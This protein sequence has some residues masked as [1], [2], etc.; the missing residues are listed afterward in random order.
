MLFLRDYGPTARL[1]RYESKV[2]DR[3][4]PGWNTDPATVYFRGRPPS[5]IEHNTGGYHFYMLDPHLFLRMLAL[6]WPSRRAMAGV[7]ELSG[8]VIAAAL[9][10]DA[11]KVL[12]PAAIAFAGCEWDAKRTTLT[13][14]GEASEPT[15]A[16]W[17]VLWKTGPKRVIGPGGSRHRFRKGKLTL[18][19]KVA[20]PV[21]WELRY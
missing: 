13:I 5:N 9:V 21:E 15:T 11:P 6:D 17:E 18:T 4:V 1:Q 7:K 10:A 8:Q 14:R 19:A 20:G 12:C 2:L 3:A 16:T